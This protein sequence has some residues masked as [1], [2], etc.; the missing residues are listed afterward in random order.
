LQSP[1]EAYRAREIHLSRLAIA[2]VTAPAFASATATASAAMSAMTSA[3]PTSATTMSSVAAASSPTSTVALLRARLIH[4]QRTAHKILSVQGGNY[5]FSFSVVL[6]FS[7]TK[8]TR[9]SRE[10]VAEKGE[11][12][13]LHANFR[14]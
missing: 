1:S 11:R 6:N 13:R 9:L 5:F 12:I 7:K 10:T 4:H 8:A 2:T 3:S 14:E